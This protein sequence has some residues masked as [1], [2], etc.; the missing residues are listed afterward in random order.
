M[1][2]ANTKLINGRNNSFN[3][4]QYLEIAGYQLSRKSN[5]VLGIS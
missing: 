5:P 1:I 4:A 3:V 2:S